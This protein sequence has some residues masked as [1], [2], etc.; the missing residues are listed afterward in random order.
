MDFRGQSEQE[1][2]PKY[3]RRSMTLRKQRSAYDS[4]RKVDVL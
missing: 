1:D 4:M 3:V 2:F